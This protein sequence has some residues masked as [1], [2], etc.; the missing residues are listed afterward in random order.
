MKKNFLIIATIVATINLTMFCACTQRSNQSLNKVETTT[1]EVVKSSP[2]LKLDI[3]IDNWTFN[4]IDL[5]SGEKLTFN[6]LF[7]QGKEV[8]ETE[9]LKGNGNSVLFRF[10]K[11]K[12]LTQSNRGE[13]TAIKINGVVISDKA[14]RKY[15]LEDGTLT[16][17]E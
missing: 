9:C 15:T 13:V 6:K 12:K 3:N 2:K 10:E 14:E 11:S 4:F 5:N 1:E 17:L 8:V 16:I 7:I